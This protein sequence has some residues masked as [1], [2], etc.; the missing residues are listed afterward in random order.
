[1]W[2]QLII[3]LSGICATT[4]YLFH[5]L[6]TYLCKQQTWAGSLTAL[7]CPVRASMYS[8]S[9]SVA[10]RHS[11]KKLTGERNLNY[12]SYKQNGV[13]CQGISI[14][15]SCFFQWFHTLSNS[16]HTQNSMTDLSV[17]GC[18]YKARQS[19]TPHTHLTLMVMVPSR[20]RCAAHPTDFS[21]H[22]WLY[23]FCYG[24]VHVIG[25]IYCWGG[26]NILLYGDFLSEGLL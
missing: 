25:Q 1:M 7:S 23:S 3:I 4:C 26:L 11:W 6:R 9:F 14:P 10:A 2:L 24:M 22:G 8:L 16:S 18:E 21:S 12:K 20:H 15:L 17:E 13:N 19:V 5:T